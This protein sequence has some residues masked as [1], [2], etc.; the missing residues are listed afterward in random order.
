M[1]LKS[2]QVDL[3]QG[4]LPDLI[5][6]A[7][8]G[9]GPGLGLDP[10]RSPDLDLIEVPEGGILDLALVLTGEGHVA[11]PTPQIT[12]GNAAAT[13]ILLCLPADVTLATGG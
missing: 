7:L 8:E 10:D 5:L 4:L 9:P 3:Q 12:I 1:G 13:V 11:G 2:Q 6:E